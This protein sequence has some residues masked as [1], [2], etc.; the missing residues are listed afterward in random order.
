MMEKQSIADVQEKLAP[1]YDPII[2]TYVKENG[3]HTLPSQITLIALKKEK[4][5]E[6]WFESGD[7]I[8]KIKSYPILAASGHLGPKL[9]EGDKQ[10]PEGVYGI[11]YFNPNSLF[12]LSMKISY[13]NAFD[14]SQAAKEGRQK[15]G[16]D[17]FIHGKA[18]SIGC[19][20]IGDEAIEELF[21]LSTLIGKEDINII[22]SPYDFRLQP[23]PMVYDKPW[24][25][26]LYIE[27]KAALEK[28]I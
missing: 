3:F 4:L 24:I 23:L 13:P 15:L 7:T 14:H 10:V 2:N 26:D 27:I 6:L 1:I 19:I 21:Y 16:G 18:S 11:E 28:Y 25:E 12:Y 8:V 17:I 9:K 22:M 5:L 20:A